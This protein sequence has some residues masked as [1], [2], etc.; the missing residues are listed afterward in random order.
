M[1]ELKLIVDLIYQGGL[2]Y[3]RYSVSDTAEHGDYTGGPRIVTEATK[4]DMKQMLDDIQNGDYANAWIAENA[5]GRPT[6][7]KTRE[8]EQNQLIEQVGARLREADAV[9]QAG[10]RV[11]AGHREGK[12]RRP[13]SDRL[14][15]ASLTAKARVV[16][17]AALG[18]SESF[19][20]PYMDKLVERETAPRNP[21]VA[22]PALAVQ[23]FLIPLAVVAVAVV[24]YLGFRSLLADDRG[25]Q[26]YLAE[27]QQRRHGSALAGGVRAVA[28]DGRPEGPR[29]PRRSAPA[30][31]KAF[32]RG[33]GRRS[34]GSPL[35][36]A[37]DRPARSAAAARGDRVCA[38][39]RRPSR[40]R[41]GRSMVR[42]ANRE[43]RISTIWALGASGDPRSCRRCSRS[44]SR[45]TPGSARW[46]CTRSA[47]CPETRSS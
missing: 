24:V 9:P 43:V 30:L 20:F 31:V 27:I 11:E 29:G 7:N 47:R 16:K 36:G 4:R 12:G 39:A 1:H 33:Q 14:P 44:T 25:A 45:P 18:H 35:S 19:R 26:D 22:A 15:S 21:L 2:N 28:V 40:R 17:L 38:I 41:S 5:A 13:R 37:G 46:W 8:A 42:Q 10:R 34:A 23:F 6:F 32:E 3:M